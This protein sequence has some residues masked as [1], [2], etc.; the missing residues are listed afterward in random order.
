[1]CSQ[2]QLVVKLYLPLLAGRLSIAQ[3]TNTGQVCAS[4]SESVKAL[5]MSG[6]M[7]TA[8]RCVCQ[9]QL[10]GTVPSLEH[11]P[12]LM[13]KQRPL[14]SPLGCRLAASLPRMQ[15]GKKCCTVVPELRKCTIP[16]CFQSY[17]SIIKYWA[18]YLIL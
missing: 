2:G 6:T 8:K 5:L 13:F 18:S 15:Q 7:C 10:Y 14:R 16:E 12:G 17:Y 3:V 4:V 1:M 11:S 9:C